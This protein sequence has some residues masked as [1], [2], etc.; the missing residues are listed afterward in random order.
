MKKNMLEC[1]LY[2]SPQVVK[3]VH[4]MGV[5]DDGETLL[6][7]VSSASVLAPVFDQQAKLRFGIAGLLGDAGRIDRLARNY[8]SLKN[9]VILGS[10][11]AVSA[12][13]TQGA[14]A[15]LRDVEVPYKRILVLLHLSEMERFTYVLQMCDRF[16]VM[17]YRDDP[18]P[19][20][21]PRSAALLDRLK[22]LT[23]ES[24]GGLVL[25]AGVHDTNASAGS[26]EFASIAQEFSRLIVRPEDS[27]KEQAE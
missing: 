16:S 24:W 1:L 6:V 19:F 26:D 15:I 12:L 23:P 5:A 2:Q 7:E 21:L 13:S 3:S 14:L 8:S 27:V 17:L 18:V 22:V 25:S 11:P 10:R 20:T 9:P 4:D